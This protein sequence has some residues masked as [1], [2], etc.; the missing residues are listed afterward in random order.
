MMSEQLIS[1]DWF[2]NQRSKALGGRQLGD[3]H[4]Y[5]RFEVKEGDTI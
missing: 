1:D 3:S 4:A 2:M 5:K